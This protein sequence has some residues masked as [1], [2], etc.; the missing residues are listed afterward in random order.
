[1]MRALEPE[2]FE[3]V[4]R[5]VKDRIPD[6]PVHPY[7][8]CRP[9]I[10]DEV[11]F[12][13]LF[14]RFVSGA[15]WETIEVFMG[16]QVSDTTLRSRRDEWVAAGIFEDLMEHA[17]AEYDRLVGIDC[18]HVAID[19]STQLAPGGGPDT[20]NYPGSK[21]RLGYKWSIGVDAAG[22][23]IGFVVDTGARND[24]RLLQPTLNAITARDATAA[25]GTLHL[26]RGYSYPSLPEHLTSYDIHTI[27]AVPR[28]QPGQG[29]IPLV[30]LQ[31]R[32]IVERT[33][34]WLTNFRQLKT[35]WDRHIQHRRAALCLALAVICLYKIVDHLNANDL[36]LET[37]R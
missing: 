28:N 21:G 37:I 34:A 30:G 20:S 18:E 1:M 27:N 2:M 23:G 26:D 31:R 12:K 14:W 32:W 19:G 4:F 36:P 33:N 11:C 9:R 3:M 22:V 13:G 17:L 6:P 16:G 10:S 24:Y 7:G 25:I 15:A 8:A 35:N 29:R 5:L